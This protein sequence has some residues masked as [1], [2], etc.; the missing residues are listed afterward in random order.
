[1]AGF[2]KEK[3]SAALIAMFERVVPEDMRVQTR[4]MFGFPAAFANGNMAF[5]LY[6][7]DM[8]M[9]L[10]PDDD[11]AFARAGAKPFE[12]W[13]GRSMSGWRLVPAAMLKDEKKLGPW[14]AKAVAHALASPSKKAGKKKAAPKKSAPKK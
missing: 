12:P 3:P 11:A 1:M 8:V 14:A 9:K 4:K 13:P 2:T 6:G 7:N 5:G 10:S